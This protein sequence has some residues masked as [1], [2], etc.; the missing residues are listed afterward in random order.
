LRRRFLNGNKGQDGNSEYEDYGSRDY[1]SIDYTWEHQNLDNGARWVRLGR[2][3]TDLRSGGATVQTGTRYSYKIDNAADFGY[4]YETIRSGDG[5]ANLTTRTTHAQVGGSREWIL[6]TTDQRIILGSATSRHI[7]YRYDGDGNPTRETHA[8]NDGSDGVINR[9]YDSYGNVTSETDLNGNTT[10]Y[11]YTDGTFVSRENFEGLVTTYS[12]YNQ[13]GK[14]AR[15]TDPNGG[16]TRYS[17]DQYGVI[18]LDNHPINLKEFANR[19]D[20]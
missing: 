8:N 10:S 16:T 18:N 12:G 2:E 17:Y 1:L 19:S 7:S 15:S 11:S 20:R 9:D 4:L 5:E 14:P 6:R 13:W 3:A